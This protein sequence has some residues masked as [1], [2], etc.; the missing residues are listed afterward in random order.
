MSSMSQAFGPTG[1]RRLC[2]WFNIWQHRFFSMTGAAATFHIIYDLTDA[3]WTDTSRFTHML[4]TSAERLWSMR[5]RGLQKDL[6]CG[7]LWTPQPCLDQPVLLHLQAMSSPAGAV[8]LWRATKTHMRLLLP[9]DPPLFLI[10]FLN[11]SAF[12][13]TSNLIKKNVT[14]TWNTHLNGGLSLLLPTHFVLF[15]FQACLS[16]KRNIYSSRSRSSVLGQWRR[17]YCRHWA[18]HQRLAHFQLFADCVLQKHVVVQHQHCCLIART[19]K[20]KRL[21]HRS[22]F[23]KNRKHLHAAGTRTFIMALQK[24]CCDSERYLQPV[25]N[26]RLCT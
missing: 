16:C 21:T 7:R 2:C 6:H 3:A 23:S 25:I 24:C 12:N 10:R 17:K 19:W 22:G 15:L 13:C 9:L 8:V 11:F 1:G 20:L 4:Q 5:G 26:P 18:G 14:H